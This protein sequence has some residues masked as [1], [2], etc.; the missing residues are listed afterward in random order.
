[1]Y[2]GTRDNQLAKKRRGERIEEERSVL[3][4]RGEE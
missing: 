3:K 4:R 1:V 2:G